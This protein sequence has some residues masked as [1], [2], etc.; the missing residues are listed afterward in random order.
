MSASP[1]TAFLYINFSFLPKIVKKEFTMKD[2]GIVR[3]MDMLG[4]VVIPK[5]IRT[6][7]K[8]DFGD[9]IEIYTDKDSIF[10]KKYFPV[11]SIA[12]SAGK[13]ACSLSEFTGHEVL[14]CDETAFIAGAGKNA[15]RYEGETVSENVKEL[16]RGNKT[17][18]ARF[19]SG[20]ETLPIVENEKRHFNQYFMPIVS[21]DETLGLI[22]LANDEKDK[23]ITGQDVSLASLCARLIAETV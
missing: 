4:R 23:I 21:G 10:L 8:I 3:R 22:I 16:I 11:R 17:Y 7:L 5:E 18:S 1:T 20:E 6:I 12:K 9:P 13:I 19:I 15:K 14:I 2:T